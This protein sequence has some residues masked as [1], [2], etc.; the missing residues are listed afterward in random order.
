M[1]GG[2]GWEWG[3]GCKRGEK[4]VMGDGRARDMEMGG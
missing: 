4:A 3:V 1:G 2:K